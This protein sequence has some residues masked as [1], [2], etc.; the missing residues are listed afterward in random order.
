Q[1]FTMTLGT[2]LDEV[3]LPDMRMTRRPSTAKGY[4]AYAPLLKQHFGGKLLSAITRG[5][6]LRLQSLLLHRGDVNPEHRLAPA[7]INRLVAFVRTVLYEAV[8]R[9]Y[10]DRNPAARLKML[11][12]EN[13]RFRVI[14]TL[15]EGKLLEKTPSW[16]AQAIQVALLTG[17]R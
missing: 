6:V 1:A 15:E 13:T 16:L 4:Q 7:T 14:S 10:I 5:D 12:E 2:F 9:E 8:S 17:L 3:F 11:P